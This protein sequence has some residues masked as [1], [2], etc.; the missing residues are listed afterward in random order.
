MEG[1]FKMA[2]ACRYIIMEVV[3][4]SSNWEATGISMLHTATSSSHNHMHSH[5][6]CGRSINGLHECRFIL[7]IK[8]MQE[9]YVHV[10][11]YRNMWPCIVT[12]F[13]FNKTNRRTIFPNLFLS[14]NST[15]FG[16]F[17]CPSSGVFHC[18]FGAGIC[19]AGL[20]T[21]FEQDQHGTQSHPGRAWKL[22]SNLHDIYQRRMYS[23]KL[24]MMGRG[25]LWNM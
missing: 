10:T 1:G 6:L 21:A 23:G 8:I 18:T 20:M 3:R 14:R 11:V 2:L 16:Q 17:L 15:C 4:N 19:H 25:T 24:L 9:L 12:N 13:L 7:Y 5:I 22:S